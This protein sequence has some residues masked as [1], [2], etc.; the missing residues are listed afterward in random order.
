M[1]AERTYTQKEHDLAL[2]KA[3]QFANDWIGRHDRLQRRLRDLRRELK[4]CAAV[5]HS[6]A[7]RMLEADDEQM[8][9]DRKTAARRERSR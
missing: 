1:S 4:A 7:R 6:L 5:G 9:R 2:A 8:K 3:Y